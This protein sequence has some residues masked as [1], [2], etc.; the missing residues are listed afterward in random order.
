LRVVSRVGLAVQL[1]C[2]SWAV[3]CAVQNAARCLE[4]AERL[5]A[6]CEELGARRAADKAKAKDVLTGYSFKTV[7]VLLHERK[8]SAGADDIT[9]R[10]QAV[11]GWLAMQ[12][13]GS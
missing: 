12:L 9:A 11:L 7:S 3:V 6:L 1:A 10:G 2:S 4:Q 13:M 5:V 8:L